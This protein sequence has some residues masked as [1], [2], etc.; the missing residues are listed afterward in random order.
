MVPGLPS[1]SAAVGCAQGRSLVPVAA[2]VALTCVL[3]C[4]CAAQAPPHPPRVERPVAVRDLTAEQVGTSIELRFT[5]PDSATD[6]ELLTKPIEIEIFRRVTPSNAKPGRSASTGPGPET[7]SPPRTTLKG[8]DLS[9]RTVDRKVEYSDQI[10]PA[11]FSQFLGSTLTFRVRALTR[12]FHARRI[13]GELS[14]TA[15][16]TLLDVSR[17][18]EG[19]ALEVTEKALKLRWSPPTESVSG[20]PLAAIAGYRVYRSDSRRSG[21]YRRVGEVSEP[22]YADTNF[23]FGHLYSYK[24]RAVSRE[25]SQTAESLDSAAL[26]ILPRD[27]F[28]PAAPGGLTGLYTAAAVELLWNPNTEPDLAGYNIYRREARGHAERLNAELL[29]SPLFRDT[30]LTPGGRYSYSVT[31][32]DLSGNESAASLEVEVDVPPS[33]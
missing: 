5:R 6:G 25:D 28:P 4:S 17:P 29:R 11:D 9:R 21:P 24:V 19:L 22:S 8:I 20:R 30:T 15:P 23:A 16:V 1:R 3:L 2:V 31:A 33:P 27:V 26:E 14:N 18:V 10:P 32:V 12:G 7:P 13:E